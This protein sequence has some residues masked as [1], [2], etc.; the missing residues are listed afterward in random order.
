MKNNK[1]V[2]LLTSKPSLINPKALLVSFIVHTCVLIHRFL[3]FTGVCVFAALERLIDL[4]P[5]SGLF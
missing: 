3:L 4:I 1:L 5:R 2:Y